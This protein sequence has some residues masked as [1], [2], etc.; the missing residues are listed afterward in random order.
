MK[1]SYTLH[2]SVLSQR[3]EVKPPEVEEKEKLV[4]ANNKGEQQHILFGHGPKDGDVIIL[5]SQLLTAYSMS[6]ESSRRRMVCH[7]GKK[8]QREHSC[9]RSLMLLSRNHHRETQ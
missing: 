8:F 6:K 2:S 3:R 4:Y 9:T 5:A 1:T 7:M